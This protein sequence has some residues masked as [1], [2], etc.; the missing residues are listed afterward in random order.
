MGSEPNQE[1]DAFALCSFFVRVLKDTSLMFWIENR[2]KG[3]Q[4]QHPVQY[5]HTVH[6]RE[7]HNTVSV[8]C[9]GTFQIF[10]STAPSLS[11]AQPLHERV[12]QAL[13]AACQPSAILAGRQIDDL[14]W[15]FND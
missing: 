11:K 15:E 9:L 8:R 3:D 4:D 1:E 2:P 5:Q 6:V 7:G 10:V 13:I 14:D 12:K